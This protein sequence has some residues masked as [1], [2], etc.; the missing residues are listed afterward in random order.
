MKDK[1][2]RWYH[3]YKIHLLVWV[4]YMVYEM[5]LVGLVLK[6]GFA[7]PITYLS[8]YLIFIIFFYIHSDL[9]LPIIFSYPRRAAFTVPLI[10]VLEC[11]LYILCQYGDTYLLYISGILDKMMEFDRLLI[12]RNTYRAILY[13]G[14]S[15]GYYFLKTYLSQRKRTEDLE[16]QRLKAIIKEQEMEQELTNAQNAFLKA[17]I[18]PHFLFNTLDF[19]Y[20]NVNQ[21]S[22]IAGDAIIKLSD[23][24]RFAME[25]DEMNDR[26]KLME[27]IVQVENLIH[28]YQL[29]KKN[30]IQIELSYTQK[31]AD[32][33][34][35][36]LI[37]LTLVENIFKHGDLT[38]EESPALIAIDVED[39]L[40]CLYTNNLISAKKNPK[41]NHS[42]LNNIRKRLAYAYGDEIGFF[43]QKTADEH[44][45]VK[46]EI[47]I[48]LLT[49]PV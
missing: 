24:M 32:L 6:D 17:Q 31:V 22:E 38:T 34:I 30:E 3:L 40:F 5:V 28:L 21:H 48:K 45:L 27:E 44:F 9:L 23:M 12:W 43:Y 18:N 47:P 7:N 35:I 19:V 13:M 10:L 14:F 16:R 36:P 2:V 41:S 29:R 20:H 26:I 11:A 37:L 4:L 8:H 33:W 15:T 25:S 46:I 39:H 42:G 49:S 1:L